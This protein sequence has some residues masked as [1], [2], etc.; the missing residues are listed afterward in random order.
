MHQ[1][2]VLAVLEVGVDGETNYRNKLEGILLI[3]ILAK[4]FGELFCLALQHIY[5]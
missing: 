2:Q 4:C 3:Q 5:Y 1:V